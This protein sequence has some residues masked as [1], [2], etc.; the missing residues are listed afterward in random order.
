MSAGPGVASGIGAPVR[1]VE[2]QRLLTG[3]GRYAD[4]LCPHDAAFACVVRS[5]HAHAVIRDIDVNDAR[6]TPGI[7]LVLTAED[8]AREK[9]GGL[10]CVWPPRST[11]GPSF[12]PEQPLLANGKVRHVGDPIALIVGKSL[13]AAKDAA[14]RLVVDYAALP[15][16]TLGD[17]LAENAAKV[18]DEAPGNVSFELEF[19]DKRAVAEQFAAARSVARLAV[20]YPRANAS[21]IEPRSA[22][23][24]RDGGN[25]RFT[26]VS[27]TQD[28]FQVRHFISRVLRIPAFS[29]KVQAS[30][31]GGSF[32][33]KGQVYPEELLV[34]WAAAKLGV[35]VKWTSERSES[36]ASD[37]HGRHQVAQAEIALDGN[38]RILALRN[39]VLV[40]IGA[41]PSLAAGIAPLMAAMN[42]PGPYRIPL[43][44]SAIRAIFTNT[45]QLGPYRGTGKPE[46]T[47]VLERLM[48]KA[49]TEIG[50]DAI[51]LRRR[52]LV[53]VSDMPYRG[54]HGSV[55][56]CGDFESVLDKC[57]ALADWSGF[58][59]RR[60]D[61]ERRGL[62]R[63]IGLAF[64]CQRAG[65]ASE[66]M[67]IRVEESGSVA[68]HAGT[69]STGQGHETMF[70]QMVSSWLG[71]PLELVHV[72]HGDTDQVLFGRGSFAQR[73]MSTGGA[74]LKLAAD[75]VVR[76]ARRVGAWMME[77]A[78]DDVVFE[79]GRFRVAGT[80]REL[81]FHQIAEKSY[82]PMGLPR[83]LGVGLD[84]VGTD[85]GPS[86]HPNGCMIAEVELD[87]ETGFVRVDRLCSVDDTG[88][89]INPLTLAG[90]LHGSIAQGL[91]E[92][93]LETVVHEPGTGQLLTGSFMDYAMP[94]ADTM[95]Q[96]FSEVAP[97]PT[98][99]NP[100]GAKGGSEA[101]NT[102]AP[103]AI[104]N[105]VLNA[106]SPWG[107]T[108][109]AVPAR[110]EQVWR[111]IRDAE[112]KA[113]A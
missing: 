51:E 44:H 100:L 99:L 4:D 81:T 46:A 80:D 89:V 18:W 45:S 104:I 40:D 6:A 90:Q 72:F 62:R 64:H 68:V 33:L 73:T 36:F 50:I 52:N 112:R 30:D 86:T 7:L 17:A 55:C 102:A 1:R 8:L 74:A 67:E 78:E 97:I 42:Y 24:Y 63:G 2:D 12:I 87:P 109:V 15:A 101:G 38:G 69:F 76:K 95:P 111:A 82:M 58:V 108:D 85:L 54:P 113:A 105:A 29:I 47:F 32:G 3:R 25:G 41:Y 83:E 93:L 88:T 77:V 22:I 56:D 91:G 48:E 60:K 57:L 70:A 110:P 75:E 61:S 20:H 13:A 10:P 59:V 21:P 92:A 96:I 103:A 14:E 16:V 27:T 19:G 35:P 84:G 98:K 31:I 53:R 34:V 23:A 65:L 66:R 79:N 26:L 94:H 107:I 37:M 28:P 106:L 9:L 49:A 43:T 5:P 71:V 39:T 11:V